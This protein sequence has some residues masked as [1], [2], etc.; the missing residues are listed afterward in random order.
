MYGTLDT[1]R[2][3]NLADNVRA[4]GLPDF[5]GLNQVDS[6]MIVSALN[7]VVFKKPA[8]NIAPRHSGTFQEQIERSKEWIKEATWY[9]D[10]LKKAPHPMKLIARR[11]AIVA[12]AMI[13]LRGYP[14]KA[15][16]FWEGV[17]TL[18]GTSSV[19]TR[20][21]LHMKLIEIDSRSNKN[22]GPRKSYV[23]SWHVA[24][25]IAACWNAYISNRQLQV[26]KGLA[27]IVFKRCRWREEK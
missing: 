15:K 25:L 9:L 21:K 22:N 2:A 26:I 6:T 11:K 20:F 17:L 23:S 24:S 13:T 3:R 27:N 12:A 1:G 5:I 8:F 10:L 4:H 19:D 18:D 7:F 14:A 16:P